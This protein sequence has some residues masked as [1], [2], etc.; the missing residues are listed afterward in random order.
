MPASRGLKVVEAV[1]EGR[2]ATRVPSPAHV[3]L[4]I[5]RDVRPCDRPRVETVTTETRQGTGGRPGRPPA[6]G[7]Q[8]LG[9]AVVEKSCVRVRPV[10]VR[11][12]E[13]LLKEL[14]R[15]SDLLVIG[16]RT[17]GQR[18]GPHPPD[19]RRSSGAYTR[20]RRRPCSRGGPGRRRS[21]ERRTR[22]C[23][24]HAP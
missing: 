12:L 14:Q 17:T 1:V 16:D 21:S 23:R 8:P 5:A 15:F 7:A 18:A 11:C 20:G 13:P 3:L 19:R 10:M 24:R 4:K 6:G 9:I 22:G 2:V